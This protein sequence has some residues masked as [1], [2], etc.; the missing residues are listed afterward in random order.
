MS[1][2]KNFIA[3]LSDT[4]RQTIFH[5]LGVAAERFEADAKELRRGETSPG[6]RQLIEQFER[7]AKDTRV[8]LAKLEEGS[9]L[10][11]GMEK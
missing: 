8:M 7:Q 1:N 3:T 4:E 9:T 5:A 11:I 2:D 6:I 10:I